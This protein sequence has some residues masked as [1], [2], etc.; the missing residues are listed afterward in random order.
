MNIRP[1]RNIELPRSCPPPME[2][3]HGFART[4]RGRGRFGK[5]IDNKIFSHHSRCTSVAHSARC[6]ATGGTRSCGY[7]LHRRLF[8]IRRKPLGLNINGIRYNFRRFRRLRKIY[9]QPPPVLSSCAKSE[10]RHVPSWDVQR[11]FRPRQHVTDRP[12]VFFAYREMENKGPPTFNT[13]STTF[14]LLIVCHVGKTLM[15]H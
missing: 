14:I 2:F 5:P 12:A 10:I 1:G 7:P 8:A 4:F 9:F 15:W 3:E 6:R 13:F 11:V